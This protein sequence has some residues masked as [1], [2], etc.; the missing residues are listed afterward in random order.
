MAPVL[1]VL[2]GAGM[3]KV[4]MLVLEMTGLIH[5]EGDTYATLNFVA[6][7]AFYFLPVYTGAAETSGTKIISFTRM[8]VRL[9]SGNPLRQA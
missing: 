7:A 2:I 3:L 9:L 1:P 6:D 5:G 8:G 4:V